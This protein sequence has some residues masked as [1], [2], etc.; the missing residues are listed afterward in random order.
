MKI[1]FYVIFLVFCLASQ[2]KDLIV[3]KKYIKIVYTGIN[4]SYTKSLIIS[5][6]KLTFEELKYGL[7]VI[8]FEEKE[9]LSNLEK[10]ISNAIELQFY[11]YK[12]ENF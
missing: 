1:I 10:K 8:P 3:N 4:E 11:S 5:T 2:S 7:H 9:P 6:E 12:P